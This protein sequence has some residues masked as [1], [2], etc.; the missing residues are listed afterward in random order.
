[1]SSKLKKELCPLQGIYGQEHNTWI[2]WTLSR[3][4]TVEIQLVV[5]FCKAFNKTEEK[6]HKK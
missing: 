5:S 3:A 2:H 6:P 1:M 4:Q